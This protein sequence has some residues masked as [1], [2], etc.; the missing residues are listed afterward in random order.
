MDSTIDCSTWS[1]NECAC[2]AAD[3][4]RSCSYCSASSRCMDVSEVDENCV[5]SPSARRDHASDCGSQDQDTNLVSS[6]SEIVSSL[7]SITWYGESISF[8][9]GTVFA[10][11][12]ISV[13]LVQ[14][15][16]DDSVPGVKISDLWPSTSS[17]ENVMNQT[18][19][20][21]GT[22]TWK[23]TMPVLQ[24]L[25]L[26]SAQEGTSMRL[27]SLMVHLASY[28]PVDGGL[29]YTDVW[30]E[31][32]STCGNG[33][34]YRPSS[35]S[36]PEPAYGGLPCFEPDTETAMVAGNISRTCYE[37]WN[38][39]TDWRVVLIVGWWQFLLIIVFVS[40]K[41]L[42]CIRSRRR[43]KLDA[44]KLRRRRFSSD[45]DDMGD[46]IHASGDSSGDEISDTSELSQRLNVSRSSENLTLA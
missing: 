1:S 7:P 26:S 9:L 24:N 45:F 42:Q 33:T 37:S 29:G 25:T 5:T 6:P 17:N 27:Q 4:G 14:G 8:D 12:Y 32:S 20:D 31:C 19:S 23:L 10:V 30:S 18:C 40:R 2:Y 41:L 35:C 46:A 22:C 15:A 39:G 11:D 13:D 36:S 44:A 38:C 3:L 16:F 34:Q 43:D 21:V 28:D